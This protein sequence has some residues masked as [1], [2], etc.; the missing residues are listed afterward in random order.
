MRQINATMVP[1][2]FLPGGLLDPQETSEH[3]VYILH[4]K[5]KKKLQWQKK[6]TICFSLCLQTHCF[7]NCQKRMFFIWISKF[8]YLF[9]ISFCWSKRTEFFLSAK[10]M[11]CNWQVTGSAAKV[12]R[13]AF[14]HQIKKKKKHLQ[15]KYAPNISKTVIQSYHFD[16]CS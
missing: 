8:E 10:K 4:G 11:S 16:S 12:V 2:C 3:K 7:Y 13:S 9:W 6:T 1:C 15:S 14:E 5:K